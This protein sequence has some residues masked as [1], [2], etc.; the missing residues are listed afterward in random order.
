M[1]KNTL[2]ISCKS[3]KNENA[4]SKSAELERAVEELLKQLGTKQTIIP[5]KFLIPATGNQQN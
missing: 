5:P 3:P 1:M 4:E 2:F